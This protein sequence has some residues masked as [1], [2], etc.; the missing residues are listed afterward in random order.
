R[1]ERHPSLRAEEA[2]RRV[3]RVTAVAVADAVR[4][5]RVAEVVARLE[6]LVACRELVALL[7]V[8]EIADGIRRIRHLEDEVRELL[9]VPVGDRAAAAEEAVERD[10]ELLE[11]GVLVERVAS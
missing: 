11:R 10:D 7:H 9:H 5:A 8:V 4:A 3:E 2:V 6:V 1:L